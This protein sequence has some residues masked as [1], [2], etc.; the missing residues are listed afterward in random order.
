M[1]SHFNHE[2]HIDINNQELSNRVYNEKDL[3]MKD[4]C[5]SCNY[6]RYKANK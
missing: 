4:L 2:Y 3:N 5:N 1:D 6:T